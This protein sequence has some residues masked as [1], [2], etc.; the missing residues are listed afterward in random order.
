MRLILLARH[1]ESE[2]NVNPRLYRTTADH[3]ISLSRHG[4][5]QATTCGHAIDNL[6][7]EWWASLSLLT[8]IWFWISRTWKHL[9]KDGIFFR[10]PKWRPHIRVWN[11][12]YLRTRQTRDRIVEQ[13]GNWE[14][15]SVEND[16]L[17]EQN[18]GLFDGLDDEELAEEF[19]LE[20][21]HYKKLSDHS[22]RYWARMPL[23]ES[24][25]DVVQ[26]VKNLNGSIVRDSDRHGIEVI[27]IVAHGVTNRAFIMNWLHYNW[28]WFEAEPNPSNCSVRAIAGKQDM[29]YVYQGFSP[30]A[31]GPCIWP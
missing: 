26:R 2:A 9:K 4:N 11:S 10:F 28:E 7:I 30:H 19:P 8:K 17:T 29:G 16:L 5:S 3:A 6:L 1:G 12:S 20:Y 24:R 31:K 13:L 23:G 18:F 27:I 14:W 22:G 21:A 25:M 15:D